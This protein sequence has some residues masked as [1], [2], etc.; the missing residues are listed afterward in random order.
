MKEMTKVVLD[1]M[2]GDNAPH[3]IVKGAIEAIQKRDDIHVILTG[4]EDVINKELAGYT[5]NKEQI[6][7]VHAE[8][9][10]ETAEPPVMAIRRKKD[11]SIV[12][13]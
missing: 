11:S 9:I 5:Y 1:A 8:E 13:V 10:I 7:V 6:S 12:V 4:K 3:E 2:G